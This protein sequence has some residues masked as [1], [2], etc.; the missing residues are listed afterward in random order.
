VRYNLS[1]KAW[2]DQHKTLRV[3]VVELTPPLFFYA[4]GSN[5]QGLVADYLRALVLHLGLQ[6]DIVRY[7]N[8]QALLRGL[9]VGEVDA[10]GAWPVGLDDQAGIA[11]SRP[12]LSLP[13]ALYG[14]SNV[15][16]SGLRGLRGKSL[17]V[18]DGTGLEQIS[19]I[20]PGLQMVVVPTLDQALQEAGQG[21]VHAFLGDA[22]SVDYLL[23]RQSYDDLEKQLQLDLAYDLSLATLS[24]NSALL[25]VLQKG[26]DRFAPGELQ[27]IWNRWPGVDRPQHYATKIE[28]WWL[29][30]LLVVAWSGFLVWG[31]NRYVLQKENEYNHKLKRA[32][33]RLQR[34]ERALKEKLL[35]LNEKARVYQGQSRDQRQRLDLIDQV[36]PSAAWVWS[37]GSAQCQWDGHMYEL[38]GQDPEVF[39]PTPDAILQQV[40]AEDRQGVAV[41]F[42][43]P[44]EGSENRLSFR[45]LLP[46]GEVR[47]L[48]DFSEF[49][50]DAAS[51]EGHRVGL[52]WDITDFLLDEPTDLQPVES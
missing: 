33:R 19:K 27:E 42:Q 8:Q 30:L 25:G 16:A 10:L 36:L 5:P 51:G 2:L 15:S 1:E 12:Y 35:S 44:Q 22:A 7:P 31:V 20:V 17:A 40:H 50:A 18:I 32:I 46:N 47:W 9:R 34:R 43:K 6:L 29:W 37:P 52:C 21:E 45:L 13:L 28:L 14:T 49:S 41:L 4:G 39:K 48:L 26:L 3:G 23:K 38:F 24:S 11:L